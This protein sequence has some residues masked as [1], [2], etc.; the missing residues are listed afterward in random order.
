VV[1]I[2][3]AALPLNTLP[4]AKSNIAGML[5]ISAIVI[6]LFFGYKKGLVVIT[7]PLFQK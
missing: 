5:L 4:S 6:F 3:P 1:P 7:K 2:F